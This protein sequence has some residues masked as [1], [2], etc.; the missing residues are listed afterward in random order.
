MRYG[1]TLHELEADPW[2][3][4]RFTE[5]EQADYWAANRQA[6]IEEARRKPPRGR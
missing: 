1:V 2:L 4:A 5:R 6:E 3:M